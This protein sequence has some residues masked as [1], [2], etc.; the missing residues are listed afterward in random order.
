M[1]GLT[2]PFKNGPEPGHLIE[3]APRVYWLQMPLPMSLK[4]I[5]L[6][7]IEDDDG[8]I[9]VDT[10][11]RGDETKALW[12]EI[13]DR[14]FS[15]KPVKQIICTH[16]HPDHTGQAGFLHHHWQAPL[17]M[18]SAEYYQARIMAVQMKD[19]NHWQMSEHFLRNGIEQDFLDE[20]RDMRSSFSPQPEDHPLPGSFI[21]LED[22]QQLTLGNTDWQVITGTGH[23]PDH[24]CLYAPSLKLLIS[25]DQVLPIITS[26]VSVHPTEP[27]ANPLK[28]WQASHEKLRAALPDDLLVLPAHNLPFYGL[29]TRLQELIDHHEDRMLIIEEACVTPHRGVELLQL[30]F[31]RKLEG[32]TKIMALGECIAHLHC[33]MDRQRIA[34]DFDGTHY[35]YRSIAP[36]LDQR[37]RPGK[38]PA[39]TNEP[40]M[41]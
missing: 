5:N 15:T 4:F 30:M 3:V 29:H 20:L 10:G 12:L 36:D 41:V 27:Q 35:L 21:R 38:H 34:Q 11:I 31:N 22:G 24:V 17:Y 16:M 32:P 1:T 2:Y 7:V 40:I 39:P 14:Y 37:A 8:W 33:L 23:S 9:L 25:G 19:G 26:N 18:S 13:F 6:Y 28:G